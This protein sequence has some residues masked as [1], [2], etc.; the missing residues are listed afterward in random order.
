MGHIL[1][2]KKIIFISVFSCLLIQS[3]HNKTDHQDFGIL[4]AG[5]WVLQSSP[6]GVMRTGNGS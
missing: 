2:L 3:E 4:V 1:K 5:T 6:G